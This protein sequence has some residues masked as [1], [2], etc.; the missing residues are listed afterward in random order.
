MLAYVLEGDGTEKER[1]P[2]LLVKDRGVLFHSLL[3]F[4]RDYKG[5]KSD[6]C[7]PKSIC[8]REANLFNSS[9][10]FV[11]LVLRIRFDQNFMSFSCQV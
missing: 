4:R 1:M 9:S 5:V 8:Y 7:Q 6:Q 2:Q 10:G 3:R 11:M